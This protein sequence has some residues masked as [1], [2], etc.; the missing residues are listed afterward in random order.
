MNWLAYTSSN[1]PSI[2]ECMAQQR[3]PSS[4]ESALRH[5]VAVLAQRSPRFV[6]LHDNFDE[7]FMFLRLF[8]E[9]YH[10]TRHSA[11]VSEHFMQLKRVQLSSSEMSP[12]QRILSIYFLVM[13]PYAM[14][15]LRLDHAAAS[16][17]MA[18]QQQPPSLR[19]RIEQHLRTAILAAEPLVS[20]ICM[21]LYAAKGSGPFQAHHWLLGI[22]YLR[23]TEASSA[24]VGGGSTPPPGPLSRFSQIFS[25]I[26]QVFGSP[27][28]LTLFA[29]RLTEWWFGSASLPASN[30]VAPP[31][32][33]PRQF[34]CRPNE[35]GLCC[36]CFKRVPVGS[37]AVLSTGAVGCYACVVAAA[38]RGI[39]PSTGAQLQ[40]DTVRRVF[41][42]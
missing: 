13:I 28:L 27:W 10:I 25:S 42:Q 24:A 4:I 34:L 40:N 35:P 3:L 1:A 2:F 18:L 30:I 41:E 19:E 8:T 7:M 31:P 22:Q 5:S 37:V 16:T 39:C 38:Q 20:L 11:S 29:L 36:V 32:P 26:S 9:H 12:R 21:L 15:K 14:R 17:R 33:P 6:W 23:A